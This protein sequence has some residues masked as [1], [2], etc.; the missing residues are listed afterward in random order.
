M[1]NEEKR[2]LMNF[3]KRRINGGYNCRETVRALQKIG[4]KAGTI[5]QYYKIA[6]LWGNEVESEIEL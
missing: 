1:T 5:R 3:V 6:M 4:F 2:D